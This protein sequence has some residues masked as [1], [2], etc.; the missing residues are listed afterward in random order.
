MGR[1]IR[2]IVGGNGSGDEGKR[3]RLLR[4]EATQGSKSAL[5]ELWKIGYVVITIA[6]KQIN[7]RQMFGDKPERKTLIWED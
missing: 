5:R 2:S 7:L 4:E 1:I 3:I 6:G